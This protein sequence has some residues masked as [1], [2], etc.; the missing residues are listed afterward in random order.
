MLPVGELL[1]LAVLTQRPPVIGVKDYL[2]YANTQQQLTTT[3]AATTTT[4]TP[5]TTPT[6]TDM[7]RQHQ[8]SH[9]TE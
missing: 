6:T 3:A 1:P 4:T 8:H 5:T 2:A 7:H 9:D